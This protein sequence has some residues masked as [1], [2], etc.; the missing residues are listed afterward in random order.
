MSLAVEKKGKSIFKLLVTIFAVSLIIIGSFGFMRGAVVSMGSVTGVT[1]ERMPLGDLRGVVVDNNGTIYCGLCF[2]S[3]VHIYDKNGSFVKAIKINT[4][5]G[6]FKISLS[7]DND[8]EVKTARE[9]TFYKFNKNGELI[10]Q[11]KYNENTYD[12][13][14]SNEYEYR[15]RD[16]NFFQIKNPLLFPHIVKTSSD[17]KQTVIVSMPFTDWLL[18]GPF[19]AW[20]FSVIGMILLFLTFKKKFIKATNILKVR[21]ESFGIKKDEQILNLGSKK[22]KSYILYYWITWFIVLFVIFYVENSLRNAPKTH[23]ENFGFMYF[24]LAGTSTFIINIFEG[25]RFSKYLKTNHYDKWVEIKSNGFRNLGFIFS[26]ENL[27]DPNIKLLKAIQRKLMFFSWT[28]FLTIPFFVFIIS[29][30][31]LLQLI[32]LVFQIPFNKELRNI[33][34]H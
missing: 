28:L 11:E 14:Y 10:K 19:P 34:F 16:K 7:N 2:Y 30:P 33:F 5:G 12:N 25:L 21:P 8:L 32:K 9:N 17:R 13:S 22:L 18:M 1:Y 3:R 31:I 20:I 6:Y 15:D 4:G 24:V 23:F 27:N 26:R 29:T